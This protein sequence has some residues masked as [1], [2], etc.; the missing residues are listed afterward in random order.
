M[1]SICLLL[2][3]CFLFCAAPVP[4]RAADPTP[5]AQSGEFVI[6]TGGVSLWIW[7]KWKAAPHDNWW[8]NF[9]RASRLRI[10]QIRQ[11]TPDAQITWLVYR[12]AYLARGKQD[13]K[14]YISLIQSVRDAFNVKLIFFDRPSEVISYLNN[15]QPRDRVKIADFEYF[16]HSNKACWMFDY[17]NNIDSASKAWLHQDD[18]AKINRGIFSRDAWVKS[19]SCHTGESMSQVFRKCTGV[20]MTGAT[21]KTQYMD[22]ELPI[23]STPG[24]RW[25]H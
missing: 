13:S 19:W 7:E 20:A 17:S 18:M 3:A 2:A 8:M 1:R 24:G 12:P 6:L 22:D 9:V 14:D 15:G 25:V 23:I 4:V 16:G 21:G 5:T 11:Q 10:E